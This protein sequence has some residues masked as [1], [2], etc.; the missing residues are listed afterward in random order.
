MPNLTPFAMIAVGAMAFTTLPAYGVDFP[1]RKSGLWQITTR[2]T[3]G[4]IPP[5]TVQLCIDRKT[6]N[7]VQQ[8]AVGATKEHCSR[9]DLGR[10]GDQLIADT[11]CKF[12]DI[13]ATTH[14]VFTGDFDASYRVE[15]SS[16]YEPPMAGVS[17]GSA[18]IEARW[19]SPCKP[20]QHPGDLI[21]SNGLK[22]NINDAPGMRP[23]PPKE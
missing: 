8:A 17:E 20:D 15:T 19:L 22:I 23:P 21:L 9:N 16:K 6:D 14:S 4:N 5:H 12:G 10:Q 11:V 18:I 2:T 7:A 3:S 13:T 1:K